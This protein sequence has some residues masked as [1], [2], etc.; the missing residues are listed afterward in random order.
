MSDSRKRIL[1][2]RLALT[3]AGLVLLAAVS[4]PQVVR[5]DGASKVPEIF[6]DADLALG[7]RLLVEHQC[8][9][10]HARK[11]GGDGSSIYNPRGRISSPGALRGMVDLCSTE[12]KLGMFPEETTA[13][14]AVLH[15]DH[16]RFK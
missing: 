5:A 2:W 12:L 15:R 4:M 16:Y 3:G 7:E 13:V 8:A 11:V 9:A 10:C 14:A 1:V 6:R